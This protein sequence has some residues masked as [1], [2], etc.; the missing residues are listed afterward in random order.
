MLKRTGI[1]V[2][3]LLGAPA[4][5]LAQEEGVAGRW[6][7]TFTGGVS[8][9]AGGEFHE[10]GRGAVLGLATTVEAKK[11]RDV[12]DPGVGWRAGVGY[13]VSRHVEL[14]GTF[15]WERASSSELSVG[16]VA[17]LDL[18]ASFGDY[19]SY[20]VDAGLRYHLA[21]GG[22]VNPYV[23]ALAGFR[24][25]D[26]IPGTFSVPAAGVTLEDTPFFDDSTVP[27]V[28]GDVGVLFAVSPSVS[29]GVE[30]G[31]R[32]HT[33]L[34]ELEGLAGTGLENLN[35]AGSRWSVPITGVL[36]FSF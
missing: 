29:L 26:A 17:S 14:F 31:V 10:G 6:S 36:R 2:V 21:P 11:N 33:D 16:H 1:I 25:V 28:G 20:G 32:Y 7:V 27:V 3:A 35:D 8:V 19:T 23:A 22:R 5:A 12:Y 18:R 9:P 4:A 34:S 13:G 24:R 15:A 30:G